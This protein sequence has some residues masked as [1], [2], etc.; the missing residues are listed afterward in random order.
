MSW[1]PSATAIA[2]QSGLLF[3][4]IRARFFLHEDCIVGVVAVVAEVVVARVVVV[5]VAAVARVVIV[6]AGNDTPSW[7]VRAETET[8]AVIGVGMGI[9]VGTGLRRFPPD[10]RYVAPCSNKIAN[11]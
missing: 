9:G 7:V 10:C 4:I 5:V 2:R 1:S 6:D 3:A 8:E 11:K